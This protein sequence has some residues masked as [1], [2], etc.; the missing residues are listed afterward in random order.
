MPTLTAAVAHEPSQPFAVEELKPVGV[1]DKDQR[2]GAVVA[3]F[4]PFHDQRSLVRQSCECVEDLA[5]PGSVCCYTRDLG[6]ELD[7][8]G[9]RSLSVSARSV[10]LGA[11]DR[12][13]L[14]VD[15]REP[16]R[17]M[18]DA[19]EEGWKELVLLPLMT[20]GGRQ[21][22]LAVLCPSPMGEEFDSIVAASRLVAPSMDN[23]RAL[24]QSHQCLQ[25]LD[26]VHAALRAKATMLSEAHRLQSVF[27][28]TALRSDGAEELLECL[29]GIV[30][31]PVILQDAGLLV[32][33]SA[34]AHAGNLALQPSAC[35][36]TRDVLRHMTH[37]GQIGRI[38]PAGGAPARLV[39]RVVGKGTLFGYL[40][41]TGDP[42]SRVQAAL[43]QAA[44]FV[45]LVLLR[46]HSVHQAVSR[47]RQEF[48]LDL[49]A[50][51]SP[52]H[53]ATYGYKL[54]HDLRQPHVPAAFT[55]APT[56]GEG[57]NGHGRQKVLEEVVRRAA[58]ELRSPF[59]SAPV[60]GHDDGGFLVAFLPTED[61][62][63]VTQFAQRVLAR[64]RDR[65]LEVLAGSG[66]ACRVI[67]DYR[68]S[69]ERAKWATEV[70]SSLP[71]QPTHAAF[72]D[73]GVYGLL[74]D[75]DKSVPLREFVQ[76]WLGPLIDYDREKKA[77][78]TAT[79][80]CLLET[81]RQEDAATN[82]FI[83]LSTLKYRVRR[84]EEIAGVDL[85]DLE[86]QFNL[87]LACRILKVYQSTGV[88]QP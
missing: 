53:L 4:P 61:L 2:R 34:G 77:E 58:D 86:T 21:G 59:V 70:L 15:L 64:A 84:I 60:V 79:L 57:D 38:E 35:H 37:Q 8:T 31:A 87:R 82:L 1:H 63:R 66:P 10:I 80:E 49:V 55:L 81:D 54:G 44:H 42:D 67:E 69:L 73:L 5:P 56:G 36:Y 17:L 23:A 48:F 75:R 76:K 32:L 88:V 62:D 51:R 3:F 78:L 33:A 72:D 27:L 16:K 71:G 25:N 26:G 30:E 40:T 7:L 85:R 29:A 20:R 39:A 74:F 22:V 52:D 12:V 68:C 9:G 45:A 41:T 83:H 19:P 6:A 13:D 43:E 46:E 18:V 11:L 14:P 24:E 65:G 50:G 47:D 28:N